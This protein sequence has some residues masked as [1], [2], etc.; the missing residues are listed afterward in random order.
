MFLPIKMCFV[1]ILI[2]DNF[3][4]SKESRV[5]IN[6]IPT[7]SVQGS[8]PELKF[9]NLDFVEMQLIENITM[10]LHKKYYTICAVLYGLLVAT[11]LKIIIC[12]KLEIHKKRS[13]DH[14]R[15]KHFFLSFPTC[16]FTTLKRIRGAGGICQTDN[17]SHF[18]KV[19]RQEFG[20]VWVVV[21]V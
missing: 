9:A 7:S 15:G 1:K 13:A 17:Q 18:N 10:L 19:L 21:A 6:S 5:L 14:R 12:T 16:L 3:S 20:L 4:I 2:S 11:D 8:G